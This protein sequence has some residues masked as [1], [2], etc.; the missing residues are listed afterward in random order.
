LYVSVKRDVQRAQFGPDLSTCDFGVSYEP[1]VSCRGDIDYN[2]MLGINLRGA[3]LR[4][5]HTEKCGSDQ[6]PHISDVKVEPR[7]AAQTQPKLVYPDSS[8]P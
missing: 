4:N 6:E 5:N 3:D 2:G 8:T 7:A 1:K